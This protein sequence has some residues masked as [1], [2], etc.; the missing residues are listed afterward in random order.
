MKKYDKKMYTRCPH[1]MYSRKT[2]THVATEVVFSHPP[3][4]CIGLTEPQAKAE[5]GE[6]RATG[7]ASRGQWSY[8][9]RE[10]CDACVQNAGCSKRLWQSA[11]KH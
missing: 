9:S 11:T 6:A 5:F 7:R 4:G 8:Q 2:A 10:R 3:I 1:A